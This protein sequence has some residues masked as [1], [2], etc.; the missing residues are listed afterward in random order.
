MRA[1]AAAMRTSW[2]VV[3]TALVAF[4]SGVLIDRVAA[5]GATTPTLGP[6]SVPSK[7]TSSATLE[8]PGDAAP[9]PSPVVPGP[10]SA[11]PPVGLGATRSPEAAARPS[12]TG[13]IAVPGESC[14]ALRDEVASLRASLHR[15]QALRAET[16]GTPIAFPDD[17]DPRFRQPAL[18]AA[19][20]DA[21]RA[22]GAADAAI[23]GVDCSE[24]PCLLHGTL[25]AGAEGV[26]AA[27]ARVESLERMME[28]AYPGSA[29]WLSASGF[30]AI[31]GTAGTGYVR[32]T[33]SL[34]P[35]PEAGEASDALNKRMHFR[36]D[37]YNE[38]LPPA[39]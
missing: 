1:D 30:E 12:Q 10:A 34:Y 23:E 3:A 11:N 15:E 32:F 8:P 14:A 4:G 28:R 33:L 31:P 19:F 9:R 13:S 37:Q 16:E 21:A 7:P 36:R 6:G 20:A 18:V 29:K 2:L 22:V 39:P 26:D 24:Y 27:K 5:G 35:E 38:A 25:A 17:L